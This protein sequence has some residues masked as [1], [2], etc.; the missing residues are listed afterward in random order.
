MKMKHI[1]TYFRSIA[2]VMFQGNVPCGILF[3]VGIFWGAYSA[4][5]P[6]VAWGAVVGRSEERRVGKEC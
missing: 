5:T 1:K 3:L 4:G 2:Q 6:A